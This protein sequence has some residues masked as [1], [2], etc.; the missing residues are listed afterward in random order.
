MHLDDVRVLV[1]EQRELADRLERLLDE[2]EGLRDSGLVFDPD[3]DV[4]DAV[5]DVDGS[6]SQK[7]WCALL[8]W[9]SLLSINARK[10]RGA[11]LD[12]VVDIAKRAGY[13]DGRGWNRWSGWEQRDSGRW[14]LSAGM[15]HL[16]HYFKEV[17]R[18]MP[19]DLDL[20][21]LPWGDGR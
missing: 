21:N 9:S 12:E 17:G 1:A 20:D 14:I 18:T 6:R 11:T 8:L 10:G 7:D 19:K 2:M 4:P 15:D 5:P 16:R 3:H 13:R